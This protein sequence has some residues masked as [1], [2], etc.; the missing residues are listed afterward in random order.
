MIDRMK[1]EHVLQRYNG[2]PEIDTVLL[3][4]GSVDQNVLDSCVSGSP[5]AGLMRLI[6]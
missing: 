3:M 2:C 6:T 4:I 5:G 1:L